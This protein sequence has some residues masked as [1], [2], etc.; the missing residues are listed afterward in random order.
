MLTRCS[1]QQ[2]N[3]LANKAGGKGYENTDNYSQC[4]LVFHG[5]ENIHAMRDSL[6]ALLRGATCF[7]ITFFFKYSQSLVFYLRSRL[8]SGFFP[9]PLHSPVPIGPA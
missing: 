3:A 4:R 5:I 8:S 1:P 9:V 7:A 6:T 2:V